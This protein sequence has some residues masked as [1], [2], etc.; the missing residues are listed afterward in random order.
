MG[1][2][3]LGL[4]A[5][6]QGYCHASR[7][8]PVSAPSEPWRH[9][10]MYLD[11]TSGAYVAAPALPLVSQVCPQPTA[12]PGPLAVRSHAVSPATTVC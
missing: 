2:A 12:D 1:Q 7:E 8:L 10:V 3:T 9:L 4:R 11:R 6:S 5:R